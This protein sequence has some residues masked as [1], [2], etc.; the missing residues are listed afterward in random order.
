MVMRAR[1]TK[2]REKIRERTDR[3]MRV[4]QQ[5]SERECKDDDKGR[6]MK[7]RMIYD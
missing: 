2:V 5:E 7:M 1:N 6:A 4:S 3:E